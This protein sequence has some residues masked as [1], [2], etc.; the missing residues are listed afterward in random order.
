[1]FKTPNW[2]RNHLQLIFY[3]L[4]ASFHTKS[5]ESKS[6]E[7]I[8]KLWTESL[9]QES[10]ISLS[11]FHIK[12]IVRFF[13]VISTKLLSL[14]EPD[15]QADQTNLVY[16]I[17]SPAMSDMMQQQQ[18]YNNI[19]YNIMQQQ[20]TPEPE[21]MKPRIRILE[22]PKSNSLRFRYQCE[23]RG[24][25]ALQGG[26]S[27]IESIFWTCIYNC[28]A[29]APLRTGRL[30]PRSRSRAPGGRRWWWWAASPTTLTCPGHTLTIWSAPPVWVTWH[31]TIHKLH[32]LLL[33]QIGVFHFTSVSW[34]R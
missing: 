33:S 3:N 5:F 2:I 26:E 16:Q 34:Q 15:H 14:Q 10:S 29:R 9:C 18:Q 12:Y 8:Q 1:M 19:S 27:L 13:V 32:L 20:Q 23:G 4:Q 6:A 31:M 7:W 30:T 25:G 21:Q 24:A 17:S 11:T 28:Q 22:Q